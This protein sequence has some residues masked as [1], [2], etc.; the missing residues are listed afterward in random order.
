MLFVVRI[1]FNRYPPQVNQIGT[2]S[3]SIQAYVSPLSFLFILTY[4]DLPVLNSRNLTDGV[5]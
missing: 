1:T 3:E 4:R 5:L 2:I